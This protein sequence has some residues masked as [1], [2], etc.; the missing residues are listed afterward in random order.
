MTI[1]ATERLLADLAGQAT[2]MILTVPTHGRHH[3]AGGE[4][5]MV[6]FL[7]T[8]AQRQR[9]PT[10]STFARGAA[11]RQVA[12]LA[13]QLHGLAVALVAD[14]V[15]GVD[16]QPIRDRLFELA[17][18]RLRIVQGARPSIA[19][20]GPQFELMCADHLGLSAPSLLYALDLDGVARL[21][22][23]RAF[24]DLAVQIMAATVPGTLEA[25]LP[26]DIRS[27]LASALYELFRNTEE[28]ARLDDRGN[29]LRRSLRGIHA[30]RHAIEP[31][32]LADIVGSFEPLAEWARRLPR[33]RADSRDAQMLE[34]SVF[35][36]GPGFAARWS[37]RPLDLIEPP[38]ELDA[39]VNCFS[40]RG[41]SKARS[42]AGLGLCNLV[43]LLRAKGGFL[44]LRTGRRSLYADLSRERDRAYGD[45]PDLRAWTTGAGD[46][47]RVAGT[48]V[49]LL[50][51]LAPEA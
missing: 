9:V 2:D 40:K 16:G 35:D 6:Q 42:A 51:P 18:D 25:M 14:E 15:R 32:T 41:S 30:R 8:W 22:D 28:H 3:L 1:V 10:V 21:R 17:I 37:G 46:P 11:D 12:D 49:T 26:R 20:R 34:L 48:L 27:T 45:P 33:P 5:A 19:S 39:I 50:L 24:R 7:A 43:D 31:A 29:Q 44:R 4:S 47:A 23:A 36:S 38:E 13:G